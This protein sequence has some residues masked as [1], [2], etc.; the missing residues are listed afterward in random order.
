MR[1]AISFSLIV[2]GWCL[3]GIGYQ[4]PAPPAGQTPDAIWRLGMV[5]FVIGALVCLLS[6]LAIRRYPISHA[7]L[8]ELRAGRE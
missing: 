8:E 2:S 4:V 7:K 6:L 5:T 1:M 3:S